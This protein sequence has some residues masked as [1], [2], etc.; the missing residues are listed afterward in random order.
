M[1]ANKLAY[2]HACMTVLERF[3]LKHLCQNLSRLGAWCLSA[4]IK[5]RILSKLSMQEVLPELTRKR[6]KNKE[7]T[8]LHGVKTRKRRLNCQE[9]RIN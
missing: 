6:S 5:V 7:F 9:S 4:E 2:L 8:G 1:H 3:K